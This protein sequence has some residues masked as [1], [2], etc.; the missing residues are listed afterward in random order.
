MCKHVET[1]HTN[2]GYKLV[3]VVFIPIS[4]FS[5]IFVTLVKCFWQENEALHT[6]TFYK[7]INQFNVVFHIT[8]YK[9]KRL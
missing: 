9:W 1:F 7:K 3:F 4:P 2:K 8:W 6:S 5:K